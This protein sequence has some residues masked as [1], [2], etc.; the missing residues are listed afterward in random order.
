MVTWYLPVWRV[1]DRFRLL[2]GCPGGWEVKPGN[3]SLVLQT[4]AVLLG[5]G[6]GRSLYETRA[7][8]SGDK[9]TVPSR[10]CWALERSCC[11]PWSG[12]P[13]RP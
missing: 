11:E 8:P 4:P 2:A 6:R 10:C 1:P 7:S 12:A 5:L 3:P 13:H 9:F